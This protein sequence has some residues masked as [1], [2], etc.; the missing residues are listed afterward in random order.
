MRG[1]GST[2]TARAREPQ[3]IA[4]RT[5]VGRARC[6][7]QHRPRILPRRDLTEGPE[8]STLQ[9]CQGPRRT[10]MCRG[11]SL[12]H[13]QLPKG[14][15]ATPQGWREGPTPESRAA[16]RVRIT[17]WNT[18]GL[19][20]TRYS[21]SCSC[22]KPAGSRTSSLS[23]P[24]QDRYHVLSPRGGG[25][26]LCDSACEQSI[27]TAPSREAHVQGS[28]GPVWGYTNTRGSPERSLW[29]AA[30]LAGQEDLEADRTVASDG[31]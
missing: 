19:R 24:R 12:H 2:N 22:K 6:K 26:D 23:W 16:G 3:F 4:C 20:S 25:P 29:K 27:R 13:S 14:P 30:L 5:T 17:S 8:E 21:M 7:P 15:V 1:L 10:H 9:S 18:G 28:S 31:A 11:Q